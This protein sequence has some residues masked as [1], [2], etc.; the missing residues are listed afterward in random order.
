MLMR[1]TDPIRS[2]HR[3]SPPALARSM[4]LVTGG[5]CHLSP[6]TF[7]IVTVIAQSLVGGAHFAPQVLSITGLFYP[8]SL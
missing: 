3:D 8:T 1:F 5:L 7:I 6:A 4:L 2:R